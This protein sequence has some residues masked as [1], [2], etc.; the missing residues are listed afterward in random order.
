MKDL[1]QCLIGRQPDRTPLDLDRRI[2]KFEL[3]VTR[4]RK[5]HVDMQ[6]HL[7]RAQAAGDKLARS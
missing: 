3:A 1:T 2:K 4:F 7:N 6:A 5:A